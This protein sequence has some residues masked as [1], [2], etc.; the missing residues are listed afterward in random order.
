LILE[1]RYL[2]GLNSVSVGSSV[3]TGALQMLVGWRF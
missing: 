1:G 3:K 2:M